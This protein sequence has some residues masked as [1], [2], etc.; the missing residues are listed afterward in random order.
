MEIT[1][2]SG[3]FVGE[4]FYERAEVF[5]AMCRDAVRAAELPGWG[6]REYRLLD[7]TRRIVAV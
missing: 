6:E 4:Y 7:A 2:G 3:A 5:L 1:A